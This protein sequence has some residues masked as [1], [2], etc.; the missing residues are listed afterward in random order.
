MDPGLIVLIVYGGIA[1]PGIVLA[2]LRGRR[3]RRRQGR[4]S[5]HDGELLVAPPGLPP[6]RT[7]MQV[8]REVVTGNWRV[9]VKGLEIA[10]H[11]GFC[12]TGLTTRTSSGLG[13][14]LVVQ[15]T[16]GSKK[17]KRLFAR[18]DVNAAVAVLCGASAYFKRIDLYPEGR[19]VVDANA[20]AN[21][22]DLIERLLRFAV[23]LEAAIPFL[24]EDDIDLGSTSGS[25]SSAAFS[26]E[27]RS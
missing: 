16:R 9:S 4:L 5:L 17:A 18:S 23:V 20:D 22:D 12:L 21:L 25:S 11:L 6:A 3:D 27:I 19:L 26:I 8:E 24:E 13:G 2:I 1:T 7:A 10:R 14:R 15:G